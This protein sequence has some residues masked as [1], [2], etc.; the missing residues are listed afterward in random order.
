MTETCTVLTQ[1]PYSQ[2][3]GALGSAGQL[4]PGVIA[5]VVKE[6]GSVAGVGEVGE[7]W[8]TGPQMALRYE[9]NEFASVITIFLD[10]L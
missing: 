8:V 10:V 6:D 5:R 7:L 3:Y 9:K 4:V 2:R 1:Y